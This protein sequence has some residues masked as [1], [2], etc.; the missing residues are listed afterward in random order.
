MPYYLHHIGEDTEAH[1]GHL[2]DFAKMV[3]AVR[4]SDRRANPDPPMLK[5]GVLCPD[6]FA[7]VKAGA[8]EMLNTRTVLSVSPNIFIIENIPP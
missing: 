4:W 2:S 8:A 7:E 3:R 5:P 1:R 6:L